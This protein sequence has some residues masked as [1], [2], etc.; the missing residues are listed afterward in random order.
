M[1]DTI[2]SYRSPVCTGQVT[3]NLQR[4]VKGS[5]HK[6]LGK[7]KQCGDRVTKSVLQ[8]SVEA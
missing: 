1:W 5:G 2:K 3:M 6:Q 7:P 8:K 4:N